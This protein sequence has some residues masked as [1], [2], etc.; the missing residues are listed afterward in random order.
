MAVTSH[1]VLAT[2]TSGLPDNEFNAGSG[3]LFGVALGSDGSLLW[4][5]SSAVDDGSGP[6]FHVWSAEVWVENTEMVVV[7]ASLAG[8]ATLAGQT[9]DSGS[10]TDSMVVVL[11][12]NPANG[13]YLWS[14]T[15]D[16]PEFGGRVAL[17]LDPDQDSLVVAAYIT[18]SATVTPAE[19]P[20]TGPPVPKQVQCATHANA[21]RREQCSLV[22][23]YSAAKGQIV[24][25]SVAMPELD[26]SI[27]PTDLVFS[28]TDNAFFMVGQMYGCVVF[29][30]SNLPVCVPDVPNGGSSFQ[31]VFVA[32]LDVVNGNLMQ[33]HGYNTGALSETVY[34]TSVDV[35]A[36]GNVYVVGTFRG[37]AKFGTFNLAASGNTWSLFVFKL[38]V[39]SSEPAW[40]EKVS[41]DG[42]DVGSGV[43]VT[44]S[45]QDV[46]V[47]GVVAGSIEVQGMAVNVSQ[48]VVLAQFLTSTGAI[49]FATVQ[50][51]TLMGTDFALGPAVAGGDDVVPMVLVGGFY[52]D[53]ASVF[54]VAIIHYVD[55]P[56]PPSPPSPP[57]VSGVTTASS[58]GLAPSQHHHKKHVGIVIGIFFGTMVLVASLVLGFIYVRHRSGN[59]PHQRLAPSA[60]TA[61]LDDSL[62]SPSVSSRDGYGAL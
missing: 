5:L 34:G 48:G 6:G 45:S 26:G 41:S 21:T 32:Q 13:D 60:R 43:H 33:G 18:T 62:T 19:D 61:N 8:K 11:A 23:G 27:T 3:E 2:L 29:P 37:A 10:P 50:E 15:W 1:T 24:Y 30:G 25:T 39:A 14:S 28:K 51:G 53:S 54:D 56:Q 20:G 58:S 44:P 12:L 16:V 31:G 4:T 9:F 57:I 46:M 38:D 35:D 42:A 52:N 49:E 17:A 59:F 7:V 55:T 40:A 47:V 36:E 22:V